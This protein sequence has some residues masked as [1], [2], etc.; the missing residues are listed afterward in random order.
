VEETHIAPH[1]KER[2]EPMSRFAKL[3]LVAL[4][5]V[6]IPAAVQAKP[7]PILPPKPP[8]KPIVVPKPIYVPTPIYVP[9]PVVVPEPIYVPQPVIVP[10]PVDTTCPID[11]P[12]VGPSLD[13]L[14]FQLRQGACQLRSDVEASFATAPNYFRLRNDVIA[15]EGLANQ[16]PELARCG[17]VLVFRSDLQQIA[18]LGQDVRAGVNGL[19]GGCLPP[20]AIPTANLDLNALAQMVANLLARTC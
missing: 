14:A 17:N 6:A 2:N 4:A 15:L 3:A 5:C 7:I 10:T 11:V 16:L 18:R 13:D 12:P 1:L 8:V 19:S 20:G 9:K